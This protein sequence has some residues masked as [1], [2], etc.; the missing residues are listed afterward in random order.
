MTFTSPGGKSFELEVLET[1]KVKDVKDRIREL[2]ALNPK[3]VIKLCQVVGTCR[4]FQDEDII[5]SCGLESDCI[6]VIKSNPGPIILCA[7]KIRDRTPSS[8]PRPGA[9]SPVLSHPVEK[10]EISVEVFR[11]QLWGNHKSSLL[12]EVWE[13]NAGDGSDVLL[14]QRNLYHYSNRDRRR[15]QMDR[16]PPDDHPADHPE[17]LSLGKEDK[18]VQFAKPGTFVQMA[19]RVGAGGG[20]EIYVENWKCVIYYESPAE[21]VSDEV[22]FS[23]PPVGMPGGSRLARFR[24]WHVESLAMQQAFRNFRLWCGRMRLAHR[25]HSL[26]RRQ[27]LESMYSAQVFPKWVGQCNASGC[28]RCVICVAECWED[29]GR[30]ERTVFTNDSDQASNIIKHLCFSLPLW[31]QSALAWAA[32]VYDCL[33]PC[34]FSIFNSCW[35]QCSVRETIRFIQDL[36][37]QYVWVA[38]ESLSL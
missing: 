6:Q 36:H 10:L 13:K 14:F 24:Y 17:P 21:E 29:M 35:E 7:P 18:L 22:E 3:Q 4:L 34:F 12:L 26:C 1:D 20:H 11:D 8:D 27:E 2:L 28:S 32:I 16:H 15:N 5:G 30:T 25:A 33:R 19:Y 37:F 38:L 31:S 9:R 23:Y